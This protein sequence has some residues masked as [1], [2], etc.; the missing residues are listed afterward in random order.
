MCYSDGAFK[1]SQLYSKAQR[2]TQLSVSRF[3]TINDPI[4]FCLCARKKK[5]T[6]HHPAII[7]KA[8]LCRWFQLQMLVIVIR[9]KG[10]LVH[11]KLL[12]ASPERLSQFV[13]Q[14]NRANTQVWFQFTVVISVEQR[15]QM[16]G[17][18]E[19]RSKNAIWWPSDS[20]HLE[21]CG[22]IK[23]MFHLMIS[24]HVSS[25]ESSIPTSLRWR[26]SSKVHPIYISSCSC[27][28][29]FLFVLYMVE[30][31]PSAGILTVE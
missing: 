24:L 31:L 20:K 8:G 13:F 2:D 4:L 30:G 19:L 28:F 23:K 3:V 16:R 12:C 9:S 17:R 6:P 15:K 25:S 7:S 21:K 11:L 1:C 26:T 27:E 14:E 22:L 29:L 18:F 5:K 10:Q